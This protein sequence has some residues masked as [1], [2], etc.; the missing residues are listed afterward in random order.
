[1]R[2]WYTQEEYATMLSSYPWKIDVV[3]THAP[4]ESVNDESDSAHTG[5]TVLREYV[6]VVGPQYLLHGH[7]FPDPPLEQVGRTSVIYTHG[8]RI[9]TL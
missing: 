5:I 8:M 2:E 1:M 6:D 4:P 3:V 9:V 7:T